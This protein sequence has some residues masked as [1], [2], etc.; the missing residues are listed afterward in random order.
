MLWV[1]NHYFRLLKHS[2]VFAHVIL[3]F[4]SSCFIYC[5]VTEAPSDAVQDDTKEARLAADIAEDRRKLNDT[6]DSLQSVIKERELLH[7]QQQ[8]EKQQHHLHVE[9]QKHIAASVTEQQK[10][11]QSNRKTSEEK[12]LDIKESDSKED[13]KVNGNKV[14]EAGKKKGKKQK[15]ARPSVEKQ[16]SSEESRPEAKDTSSPSLET[17]DVKSSVEVPAIQVAPL[18]TSSSPTKVSD[19]GE[20][21]GHQD[22]ARP[23]KPV[24]IIDTASTHSVSM[25]TAASSKSS[26][27]AEAVSSQPTSFLDP[28]APDLPVGSDTATS[29]DPIT[30]PITLASSVIP[31]AS[32]NKLLTKPSSKPLPELLSESSSTPSAF[33][34]AAAVGSKPT[35]QPSV[36]DQCQNEKTE[37]KCFA[38]ENGTAASVV[39]NKTI[40]SVQ[41]TNV[42]VKSD[43]SEAPISKSEEDMQAASTPA[44]ATKK[45]KV[46]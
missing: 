32:E 1:G 42:M 34:Y 36:V 31:M 28:V 25:G 33:S 7:K 19:S 5:N 8:L 43:V 38:S 9:L 21:A 14:N 4:F 17:T 22:P 27:G 3:F 10:G 13:V 20:K 26:L 29:I 40:S 12:A 35:E 6:L 18:T 39:T 37:P 2:C 44:S 46:K 11:K 41:T 16:S 15:L 24:S 23:S 30:N 45:G